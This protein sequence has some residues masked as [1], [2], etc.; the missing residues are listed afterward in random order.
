MLGSSCTD[1]HLLPGCH[2]GCWATGGSRGGATTTT[3]F[4]GHQEGKDED[5]VHKDWLG[6]RAW[7]QTKVGTTHVKTLVGRWSH[8]AACARHLI[9]R[10]LS[11]ESS[12]II[13]TKLD[14][15]KHWIHAAMASHPK[16]SYLALPRILVPMRWKQGY[17]H[18]IQYCSCTSSPINPWENLIYIESSP[19]AQFTPKNAVQPLVIFID[20]GLSNKATLNIIHGMSYLIAIYLLIVIMECHPGLHG[21][22]C[23]SPKNFDLKGI[24]QWDACLFPFRSRHEWQSW[25]CR[26]PVWRH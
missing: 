22:D 2:A 8:H 4:E 12:S 24:W 15:P 18:V 6:R 26:R 16:G 25:T 1:L 3:R 13:E 17:G 9:C 20:G 19:D 14:E 11:G 7:L 21:A 10:I 5:S 23:V